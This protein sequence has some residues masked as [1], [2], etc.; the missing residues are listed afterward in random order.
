MSLTLQNSRSLKKREIS[1]TAKNGLLGA[2]VKF[3]PEPIPIKSGLRVLSIFPGSLAEKSGLQASTDY[4]IGSEHP[5]LSSVD[6]T[7]S[8]ATAIE[9]KQKLPLLVYNVA[10]KAMKT[11][12]LE[13]ADGELFGAEII[14]QPLP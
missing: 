5:F 8:W 2:T 14:L 4:L 11:L 7:D 9:K 12:D 6:F 13:I 3:E 10:S 1:I